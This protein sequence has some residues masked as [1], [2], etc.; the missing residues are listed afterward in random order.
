[1]KNHDYGR[2]AAVFATLLMKRLGMR[3]SHRLSA[4][5][6]TRAALVK[7]QEVSRLS[8][9]G[10]EW[11]GHI[12]KRPLVV[13]RARP[14]KEIAVEK[15]KTRNERRFEP[16]ENCCQARMRLRRIFILEEP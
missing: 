12:G 15:N 2:D 7:A 11:F 14:A 8:A 3:L 6:G 16:L 9:V 1:M 13:M 4:Q 5:D 10:E